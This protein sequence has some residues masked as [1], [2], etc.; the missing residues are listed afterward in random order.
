MSPLLWVLFPILLSIPVGVLWRCWCIAQ[1]GQKRDD[2]IDRWEASGDPRL[3]IEEYDKVSFGEHVNALFLLR[4]AKKLYGPL[5]Q[6]VWD[7]D[8][9]QV[10]SDY[11]WYCYREIYYGLYSKRTIARLMAKGYSLP[12]ALMELGFD[13]SF[14]R[15]PPRFSMIEGA[16]EYEQI[17]AMQDLVV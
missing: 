3:A 13:T 8:Q 15:A 2:L 6:G 5:L 9:Q 16:E 1:T 12:H 11:W 4:G 17:M 10:Y 14:D 7:T